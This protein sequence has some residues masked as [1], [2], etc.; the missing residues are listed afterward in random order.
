MS[1]ITI[2]RGQFRE[3]VSAAVETWQ[4]VPAA[5][6]KTDSFAEFMMFIQN[7]TFSALLEKQLF[8][9]EDEKNDE[10]EEDN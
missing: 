4:D 8:G 6:G 2:T 5:D 10:N 1:E 9:D 3:A 7:M